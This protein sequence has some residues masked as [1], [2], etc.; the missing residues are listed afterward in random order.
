MNAKTTPIH[1]WTHDGDRVLLVRCGRDGYG[2]FVYPTSGPVCCPKA[3]ANREA[4]RKPTC[5]SGGLFGWPW[6][7][8]IGEGKIPQYDADWPVISARVEDVIAV[9]GKAK[10]IGPCEVVYCGPWQEALEF[11]RPGQLAWILATTRGVASV[12]GGC[13]VAAATGRIGAALTTGG[14]GAASATEWSGVAS[15]TGRS[16]V[17]SATGRGG[18]AAATGRDGA[19][20]TT[21][22]FGTAAATGWGGTA[23]A[24]GENGAASATGE[25][26]AASAT[27]R[28]G[29]ASATGERGVASAAGEMSIIE[30]GPLAAGV[31]TSEEFTWIAHPGAVLLCRWFGCG[32]GYRTLTCEGV[33]DGSRLRVVRGVI[34]T[35]VVGA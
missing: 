9:D 11:V 35:E 19:A 17:A 31:C 12:T 15:A 8:G 22:G 30:V 20:L 4:A 18:A 3:A 29:A 13:G 5:N 16:G 24:T 26:G 14:C 27:G 32:G 34:Q 21:G 1:Q 2:G 25:R 28:D 7:V 6:G 10:V 23:A 33:A